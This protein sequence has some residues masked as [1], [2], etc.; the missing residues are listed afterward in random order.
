MYDFGG[1]EGGMW[2]SYVLYDRGNDENDERP[3]TDAWTVIKKF[4]SWI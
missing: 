4:D 2:K 3:L 1:E